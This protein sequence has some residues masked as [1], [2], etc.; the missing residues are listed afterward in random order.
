MGRPGA[1]AGGRGPRSSSGGISA[2][3]PFSVPPDFVVEMRPGGFSGRSHVPDDIAPFDLDAHLHGVRLVVRIEGRVAA[4]V[5]DDDEVP[6]LL[7][8]A[9]VADHPVGRGPHRGPQAGGNVDSGMER[10]L[11]AEGV[12]PVAVF[13]REAPVDGVPFRRRDIDVFLRAQVILDLLD[14]VDPPLEL[15][16]EVRDFERPDEG[17]V[18]IFQDFIFCPVGEKLPEF[19]LDRL[20]RH[21]GRVPLVELLGVELHLFGHFMVQGLVLQA[22]YSQAEQVPAPGCEQHEGGQQSDDGDLQVQGPVVVVGDHH[23]GDAGTRLLQQVGYRFHCSS[24]VR[25]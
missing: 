20:E 11:A 16:D 18:H 25:S 23:D 2:R 24:T 12:L 5:L 6:A 10:P 9:R 14:R 1:S 22:V 3:P 8:P 13:G 21:H 4:P 17:G 15:L 19:Q 7:R